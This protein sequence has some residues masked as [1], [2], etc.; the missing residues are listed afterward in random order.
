MEQRKERARLAKEWEDAT[1]EMTEEEI[2]AYMDEI[3]EWKRGALVVSDFGK[4]EEKKRGM[5]G[6][7][8][9]ALGNKISSTE[10][11]Q[12]FK[13]SEE[14]KKYKDMKKEAEMFKGDLKD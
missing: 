3:P 8:K 4:K 10:A 1:K 6:R 5:F 7:A 12:D 9:D 11:F 14:F 2:Q 13:E